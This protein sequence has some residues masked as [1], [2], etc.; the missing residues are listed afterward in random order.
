MAVFLRKTYREG[1]YQKEIGA[2]PKGTHMGPYDGLDYAGW[3]PEEH[4]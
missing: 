2:N 3:L 4:K 1:F